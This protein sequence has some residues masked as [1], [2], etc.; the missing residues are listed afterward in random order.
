M[1]IYANNPDVHSQFGPYQSVPNDSSFEEIFSIILE[2]KGASS[3]GDNL[4][5]PDT[6][7]TGTSET[8]TLPPGALTPQVAPL[9]SHHVEPLNL[10]DAKGLD[11]FFTYPQADLKE[12]LPQLPQVE[13]LVEPHHNSPSL[14]ASNNTKPQRQLQ[15]PGE[16]AK[17]R[18]IGACINCRVQKTGV[19]AFAQSSRNS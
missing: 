5:T 16:T 14:P 9:D 1:T 7:V 4:S 12:P 18:A 10:E 8:G 17:T 6:L 3:G 11:D 13:N 2:E 19:R 15:N